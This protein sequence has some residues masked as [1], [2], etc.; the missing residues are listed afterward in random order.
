MSFKENGYICEC[1]LEN[2]NVT[3][4]CRIKFCYNEGGRREKERKTKRERE[5]EPD[6]MLSRSVR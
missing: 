4:P 1:Q 6:S 3:T 5:R 2:S